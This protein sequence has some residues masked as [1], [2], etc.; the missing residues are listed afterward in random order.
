VKECNKKIMIINTHIR[1]F[2]IKL[3]SSY[4]STLELGPLETIN[5]KVED[6]SINTKELD[7]RKCDN[8]SKIL[9]GESMAMNLRSVDSSKLIAGSKEC[10]ICIL[11]NI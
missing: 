5:I 9:T 6:K 2:Y 4:F 7:S 1:I 11:K 3:E 10:A 8:C